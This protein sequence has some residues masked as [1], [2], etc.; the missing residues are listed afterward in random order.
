MTLLEKK[1]SQALNALISMERDWPGSLRMLLSN[2]IEVNWY[3]ALI[4]EDSRFMHGCFA[5]VGAV[6]LRSPSV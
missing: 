3:T 1:L 6:G 5:R 4:N 2:Q